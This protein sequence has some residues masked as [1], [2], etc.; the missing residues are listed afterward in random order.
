MLEKIL[1]FTSLITF[2][3]LISIYPMRKVKLKNIK[4]ER[5]KNKVYCSLKKNHNL[6]SVIFLIVSLIHGILAIKSGATSGT[7]SGKF[8]WMFILLMSILIAFRNLN[9]EK[10][11]IVHR[12]MSVIATVLIIIHIGVTLI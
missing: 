4:F 12:I 11:A 10:W 9:K 6:L 7:I 2:L 3:M 1:S 8:A 5:T